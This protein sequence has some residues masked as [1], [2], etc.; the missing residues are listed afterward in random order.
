MA[1]A[2]FC[3]HFLAMCKKYSRD[4]SWCNDAKYLMICV[5]GCGVGFV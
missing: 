1:L 4:L 2:M 3:T 5:V